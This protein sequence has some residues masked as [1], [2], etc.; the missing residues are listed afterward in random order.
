[1]DRIVTSYFLLHSFLLHHR[2]IHITS[3]TF[4]L[5]NAS[6]SM[7]S[8][9]WMDVPSHF[10]CPHL[11]VLSLSL[12][13]SLSL[14]LLLSFY[15]SL[16][17]IHNLHAAHPEWRFDWRGAKREKKQE[18][19]SRLNV[20]PAFYYLFLSFSLLPSSFCHQIH[21]IKS[22]ESK[23]H[24]LQLKQVLYI[25]RDATCFGLCIF[26][27]RRRSKYCII[28][29]ITNIIIIILII[30]QHIHTYTIQSWYKKKKYMKQR[31]ITTNN[32]LNILSANICTATSTAATKE[33]VTSLH[34]NTT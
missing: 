29:I 17:H 1:M 5:N 25:I 27:P 22:K 23:M 33:E 28:I 6:H 10:S 2:R 34:L 32:S 13:L 21:S 30:S 19:T 9:K 26:L 11:N 4:L 7:C 16:S 24:R 3:V 20:R 14:F 15:F 12:S 18:R 31:K 8:F